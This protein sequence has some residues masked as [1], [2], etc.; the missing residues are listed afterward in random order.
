MTID[1]DDD[2]WQAH[3]DGVWND[4]LLD[5]LIKEDTKIL[6]DYLDSSAEIGPHV[7]DMLIDVLRNPPKENSSRAKNRW[8]DYKTYTSVNEIMRSSTFKRLPV[9]FKNLDKPVDEREPI[10]R[11]ISKTAACEIYAKKVNQE[12]RAT[13]MQYNRARD[14]LK[15]WKNS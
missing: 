14:M 7:R 8:R 5:F 9:L 10:G 3:M 12:V 2:G 13:E 15:A 1:D 11:R 6:A 4:V